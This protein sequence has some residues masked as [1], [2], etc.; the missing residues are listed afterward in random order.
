M[1]RTQAADYD[2][3]REAI[4]RHAAKL[5]A[6]QGFAA[7]SVAELANR[8]GFSK[9]LI[10]HYYSSKEAILFDAMN[11][12]MGAL[13]SIALDPC[14]QSDNPSAELI[15]ITKALLQ[16]YVGAADYQK[17]LLYELAFLPAQQQKEIREKQRKVIQRIESVLFRASIGANRAHLRAK[18]MLYFGMLNW[19]HTWFKPSGAMSRDELAEEI[20]KTT[21][22][23]IQLP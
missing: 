14:H 5:F 8:C 23:S 22:K 9:S 2:Q 13:L 12:H 3:K 4:T 7:A 6:S 18:V 15:E 1:A 11:E 17:I 20:A 10:Y 19:T 21:L 16:C